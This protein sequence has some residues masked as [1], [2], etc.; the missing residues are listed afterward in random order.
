MY[1]PFS[2]PTSILC[3]GPTMAGKTSFVIKLLENAS[4]MFKEAPTKILFC[5]LV[6]QPAF[7]RL[8]KIDILSLH[9]GLPERGDITELGLIKGHKVV[10]FDD[11]L[12]YIVNDINIQDYVTVSSHHNNMSIILLSQ[13]IFAQGQTAR[14]I[15][16]NCHYIVLFNN[17]R[18]VSQVSRLGSQI[19]P[20][21]VRYFVDSYEKATAV[22][23]GYLLI[24]F[25]P[26]T[27]KKYQLRTRIFPDETP[28]VVYLN[29][30]RGK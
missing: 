10:V 2:T 1:V 18:D 17:K 26:H 15:S 3:A 23:Y 29:L 22:K 21:N 28:T 9:E 12:K 20:G 4:E 25:S 19:M 27:E 7:E 11:M 8:K 30:K 14:T 5:Y 16:L 6:W 13:N 24:D